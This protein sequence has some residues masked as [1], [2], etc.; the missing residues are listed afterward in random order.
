MEN[1]RVNTV[2]AAKYLGNTRGTLEVWRCIGKG[3]RYRKIGSKVYYDLVD[4]EE[5]AN[6]RVF[7]TTDS[8]EIMRRKN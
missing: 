3:P 4:L 5:F 7:E 2:D 1:T 8:I 6:S